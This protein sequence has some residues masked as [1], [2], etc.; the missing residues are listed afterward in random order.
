[1]TAPLGQEIVPLESGDQGSST[2]CIS[3]LLT[4]QPRESL[5]H[6]ESVNCFFFLFLRFY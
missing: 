5:K 4:L 1:M 6:V 3:S 2:D